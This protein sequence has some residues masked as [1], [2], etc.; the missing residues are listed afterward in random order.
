MSALLSLPEALTRLY[1][2]V[3]PP[4]RPPKKEDA[5]RMGVLGAARIT[6][7]AIINPALTHPDLVV[8]GVAARDRKRAQEFA[9]KHGIK[10]VF[11]GYQEMIDDPAI[12][13][14]YNPLPNGLHHEWTIKAIQAGKHVLLEKPSA[15]NEKEAKEIWEK[16][17]EK[18][19]VVLEA[20][21]YRNH[22]ALH[23]YVSLQGS[24]GTLSVPR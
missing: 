14:V 7:I 2:T 20:W 4:A 23:E 8:E 17:K 24:S 18:N 6:P 13:V 11:G 19:V 16:A 3:Y 10:R 21:H 1:R 5:L 22:P 15:S 12:D 9:K